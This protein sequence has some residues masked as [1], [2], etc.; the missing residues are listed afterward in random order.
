MALVMADVDDFMR[1]VIRGDDIPAR[2]GGEEFAILMP[3]TTVEHA[4]LAAD[5]IRDRLLREGHVLIDRT[6]VRFTVSFGV[7]VALAN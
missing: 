1:A 2:Y 4:T 6:E 3:D 7:A 5:R